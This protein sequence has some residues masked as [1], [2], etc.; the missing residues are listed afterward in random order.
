MASISIILIANIIT[1]IKFTF[2]ARA[3]SLSTLYSTNNERVRGKRKGRSGDD[4]DYN[5]GGNY[6]DGKVKNKKKIIS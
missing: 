6:D 1:T 4:S 2:L 5:D 3:S